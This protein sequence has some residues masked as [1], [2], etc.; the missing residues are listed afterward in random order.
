MT[1][2]WVR[3]EPLLDLADRWDAEAEARWHA[4]RGEDGLAWADRAEEL[5]AVVRGNQ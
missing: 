3:A 1:E 5:R 4:S 2:H